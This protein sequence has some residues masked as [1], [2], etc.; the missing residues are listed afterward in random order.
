MSARILQAQLDDAIVTVVVDCTPDA[1][2]QMFVRLKGS[3][4]VQSE[5]ASRLTLIGF[6]AP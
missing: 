4:A 2:G 3:T 1:S 6:V 5:E